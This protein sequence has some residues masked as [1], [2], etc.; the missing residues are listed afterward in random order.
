[1]AQDAA[2]THHCVAY[3]GSS[4]Y[5][6]PCEE[7][8]QQEG[9]DQGVL[10]TADSIF[11]DHDGSLSNLYH[12]VD[13]EETTGSSY[14][15]SQGSFAIPNILNKRIVVK[16]EKE[17]EGSTDSTIQP[18]ARRRT[19]ITMAAGVFDRGL[20]DMPDGTDLMDVSS[21][22]SSLMKTSKISLLSPSLI[23][24]VDESTTY[25][26]S[27][28][29]TSNERR[30]REDDADKNLQNANILMAR[31]LGLDGCDFRDEPFR[32]HA[33]CTPTRPQL[34]AEIERRFGKLNTGVPMNE[35][36][37]VPTRGMKR[38]E[39]IHWLISNAIPKESPEAVLLLSRVQRLREKIQSNE[40]SVPPLRVTHGVGAGSNSSI[41][42]TRSGSRCDDAPVKASRKYSRSASK[43]TL[44]VMNEGQDRQYFSDGG[45]F[46]GL[47]ANRKKQGFGR[48]CWPDGE[49]YVGDWNDDKP[50]G[51]GQWKGRDGDRYEGGFRHGLRHGF[52]RYTFADGSYSEG[53]FVKDKLN[54]HGKR[55][56]ADGQVYEGQ[57]KDNKPHGSGMDSWKDGSQ[58]KG[59]YWE[60]YRQGQGRYTFADGGFFEGNFLEDNFEGHGRRVWADGEQYEGFWKDDERHGLGKTCWPNGLAYEGHYWKGLRD[61][62]GRFIFANGEVQEGTFSNDKL[63]KGHSSCELHGRSEESRLVQDSTRA[64]PL[65]LNN[66]FGLLVS[67]AVSALQA[68]AAII[69]ENMMVLHIVRDL[70]EG[71][72]DLGSCLETVVSAEY[73][74][75]GLKKLLNDVHVLA[76]DLEAFFR[77]F[78]TMSP[79][80]R[81]SLDS[82]VK[83]RCEGLQHEFIQIHQGL[84]LLAVAGV[85][86]RQTKLLEEA[87]RINH[88]MAIKADVGRLLDYYRTQPRRLDEAQAT[89]LRGLTDALMQHNRKFVLKREVE[90]VVSSENPRQTWQQLEDE[91]FARF[92]VEYDAKIARF[93]SRGRFCNVVEVSCNGRIRAAKGVQKA[94]IKDVWTVMRLQDKARDE[95][96]AA[97]YG[98]KLIGAVSYFFVEYAVCGDMQRLMEAFRGSQGLPRAFRFDRLK[99]VG[100]AG[101]SLQLVIMLLSQLSMGV[102]HLRTVGLLHRNIKP[103]NILLANG[104]VVKLTDFGEPMGDTRSYPTPQHHFYRAPETQGLGLGGEDTRMAFSYLSDEYSVGVVLHTLLHAVFGEERDDWMYPPKKES[105]PTCGCHLRERLEAIRRRLL[106]KNPSERRSQFGQT[107]VDELQDLQQAA[108]GSPAEPGA[109]EADQRSLAD[110]GRVLANLQEEKMRGNSNIE[111]ECSTSF[112]KNTCTSPIRPVKQLYYGNPIE[113]RANDW[114]KPN[115]IYTKYGDDATDVSTLGMW[116]ANAGFKRI[117]VDGDIPNTICARYSGIDATAIS[118]LGMWS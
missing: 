5:E 115:E 89:F 24:S 18:R 59:E 113:V 39:L 79:A 109:N 40:L 33:C 47:I 99:T 25:G 116:S 88:Q 51:S 32:S 13:D 105:I 86:K 97:V 60:G 10:L 42:K 19:R 44:E 102:A 43:N 87:R 56:F 72:E 66:A 71:A 67:G 77:P 93:I 100:T 46:E 34:F 53:T 58:Y 114:D 103:T 106:R 62:Q 112:H 17:I 48:H 81:I 21:H 118:S 6:E 16:V 98:H 8:K 20:T 45:F 69:R 61:G 54:G 75:D 78:Q 11:S 64:S 14:Q 3:L 94:H 91:D 57:W 7:S 65:V 37:S 85:S 22:G 96:V 30:E 41:E 9:F 70:Q 4:R 92:D 82:H 83:Q 28:E 12:N 84:F 2:K 110:L 95:Y 1:M 38:H 15:G 108:G 74:S 31:A 80:K 49:E 63:L 29:N 23:M 50:H 117:V 104:C 107:L 27:S 36:G 68:A 52:G 101:L 26:N 55:V 35:A 76:G 111:Y 73:E 90:R